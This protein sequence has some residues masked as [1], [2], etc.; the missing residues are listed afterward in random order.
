MS[1]ILDEYLKKAETA[2]RGITFPT[3]AEYKSALARVSGLLM[4]EREWC[5]KIAEGRASVYAQAAITHEGTAIGESATMRC[6]AATAI[7]DAI[8]AGGKND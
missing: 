3:S 8:R 5:A 4:Q 1:D 2:L 6:G 7:A